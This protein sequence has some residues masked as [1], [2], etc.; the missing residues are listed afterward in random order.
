MNAANLVGA[1]REIVSQS[2]DKVLKDTVMMSRPIGNE[3]DRWAVEIW[4]MGHELGL[5][6]ADEKLH[7]AVPSEMWKK[8]F[9]LEMLEEVAT[10]RSVRA[11]A[12]TAMGFYSLQWIRMFLKNGRRPEEFDAWQIL[13]ITESVGVL[14][15]ANGSDRL[16]SSKERRR[17]K[18][19][20]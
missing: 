9:A 14:F 11:P 10:T 7:V 16:K 1:M 2:E 19:S 3:R 13:G 4:C 20:P 8:I 6:V 12:F 5:L 15:H 18:P 17:K